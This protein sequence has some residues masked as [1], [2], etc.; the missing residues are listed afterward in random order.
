MYC[1]GDKAICQSGIKKIT[2]IK[3]NESY[4]NKKGFL[5]EIST[6]RTEYFC[7]QFFLKKIDY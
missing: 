5:C 6:G 1:K 3:K 7:H 2:R 4:Y